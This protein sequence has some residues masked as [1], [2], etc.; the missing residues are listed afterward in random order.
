MSLRAIALMINDTKLSGKA[1]RR[2]LF[3]I[4]GQISALEAY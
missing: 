1:L 2:Q 3:V 4:L